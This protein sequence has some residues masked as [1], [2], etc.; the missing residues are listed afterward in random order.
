MLAIHYNLGSQV[1][2]PSSGFYLYLNEVL[3]LG[4]I[5]RHKLA[6]RLFIN[7]NC[8]AS[9]AQRTIFMFILQVQVVNILQEP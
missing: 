8:L 6:V 7:E 1:N 5:W 2:I 9:I 4:P 3:Q